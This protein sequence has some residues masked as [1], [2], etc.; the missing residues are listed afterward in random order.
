MA[1]LLTAVMTFYCV[2]SLACAPLLAQSD[3]RNALKNSD[4]PLDITSKKF[5]ARNVTEGLEAVFEGNVKVRQGDMTLTCD[6]LE[7]LYDEER[8]HE[9]KQPRVRKLP[10][11]LQTS[12]QI[13]T[14]T[15]SGNVKFVQGERMAVAGRGLYDNLKRTITLT[16]GPPR[17]WQGSDVVVAD[18]IIIYLDENRTELVGGEE[19]GVRATINPS[20]TKK[21]K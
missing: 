21:E 16:K 11:D 5:T 18:T 9:G 19:A 13:K 15:A 17:L 10:T 3:Y 4:Q 1:I 12:G 14:I 6:L 7:I 8:S 20:K 2:F